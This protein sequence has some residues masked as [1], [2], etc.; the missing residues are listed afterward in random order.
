M[1]LKNKMDNINLEKLKNL[2]KFLDQH[3]FWIFIDLC[4]NE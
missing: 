3:N 2:L 4:N 1:F